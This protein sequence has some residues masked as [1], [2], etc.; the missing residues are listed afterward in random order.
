MKQTIMI[1]SALDTNI[2]IY[3]HD[4]TDW[5][6]RT[7]ALDT[8]D[9]SPVISTQVISEYL[10]SAILALRRVLKLAKYGNLLLENIHPFI[11]VHL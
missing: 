10:Q 3:C 6:K 2:L 8:L 11:N 1:K 9:L 4:K 5:R 7:V